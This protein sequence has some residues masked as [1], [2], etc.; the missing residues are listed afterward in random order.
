[1]WHVC[2]RKLNILQ[3]VDLDPTSQCRV[4]CL[5]FLVCSFKFRDKNL[6]PWKLHNDKMRGDSSSLANCTI[7]NRY[8]AYCYLANCTLGSSFLANCTRRYC[9]IANRRMGSQYL[10]NCT[11]LNCYLL[12]CTTRSQS[13][14]NCMITNCYLSNCTTK[15]RDVANCMLGNG[16]IAN[17]TMRSLCVWVIDGTLLKNVVKSCLWSFN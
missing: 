3:Y 12:H 7:A 8:L 16:Y 5:T 10:T 14:A 6:L 4:L 9:S 17:Y 13:F 1:M 11:I 2:G 15:N